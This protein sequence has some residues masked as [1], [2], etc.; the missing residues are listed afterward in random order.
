MLPIRKVSVRGTARADR[1]GHVGTGSIR[2]MP[3]L[4][5]L[6]SNGFAIWPLDP[7][8][9][10]LVVEIYPRVLTGSVVKRDP[11]ARR[12]YLDR[13]GWPKDPGLRLRVADSEDAFDAAASA[14]KM[15]DHISKLV[16]LPPGDQI[17]RLEGRIWT[18]SEQVAS[19]G[20]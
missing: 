5:R 13:M 4:V 17:D 9:F 14:R 18:I 7:V 12:S 6:R 16:T 15:A 1:A 8:A 2:G 10:P 20:G 11:A 3:L 19:A